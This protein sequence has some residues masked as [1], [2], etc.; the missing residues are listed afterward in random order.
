[1][2]RKKPTNISQLG[3]FKLIEHLTKNVKLYN[4]ET[5]KGIND[6]C[7]AIDSKGLIT[8]ISTELFTEKIHFDFDYIP[9]KH[10]GYK[11]VVASISDIYSMNAI[12]KQITISISVSNRFSVEFLEA[13]YSGILLACDMYKI[14]LIG[15]DTTSSMAGLTISSTVIGSCK[16]D[17]I[18][19]RNTAKENDLI[20]VTGDLGAAYLGLQILQREKEII[21]T[22]ELVIPKLEKYK[23]LLE[24]QIKPEAQK[25]LKSTLKDLKITPN[26]MID[27]SDG[28]SSEIF[29]ICNQSGL[30]CKIFEDKIPIQDITKETAIELNMNPLTP[31]LHGGE[32]YEIL[33]TTPVS[34]IDKINSCPYL[35]AIGH[36]TKEENGKTI[37]TKDNKEIALIAQGWDFTKQ[38]KS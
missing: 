22:N 20:V 19:Y 38:N 16:N 7:A 33:F 4:K 26:S 13:L 17:E 30:G 8:L 35:S 29:H 6:D 18:T 5:L 10:L 1:M 37:I 23:Y 21:G 28:L 15:G 32:D 11:I 3:E 36:T 24:R 27:I 2:K 31:S 12:P 25:N 9:V 34:N 14:D